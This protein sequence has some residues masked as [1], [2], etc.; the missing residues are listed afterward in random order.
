MTAS[1]PSRYSSV[2]IILHWL[3]AIAIMLD[4]VIAQKFGGAMEDWDRFESR[5]D[6]ASVGTLVAALFVVRLYLRLKHGAPSLP[7]EMSA[8]Q[9]LMAHL[10]RHPYE[11]K[12]L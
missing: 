4:L 8:C 2:A 6:H 1:T 10:A 3:I 12:L 11:R 9:K 5:S 7:P